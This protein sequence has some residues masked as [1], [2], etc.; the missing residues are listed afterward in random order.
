MLIKVLLGTAG[1]MLIPVVVI[2][3]VC[4]G[5]S[6]QDWWARRGQPSST[7]ASLER[8]YR[9]PARVPRHERAV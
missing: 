1:L 3:V 2:V 4:V 6:V 7:V 5:E 8:T 9:M